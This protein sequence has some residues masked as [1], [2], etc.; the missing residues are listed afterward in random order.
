MLGIAAEKLGISVSIITTSRQVELLQL[1][2]RRLSSNLTFVVSDNQFE[3]DG[4]ALGHA[5][6]QKFSIPPSEIVELV[7][8]SALCISD[9]LVWPARFANRF[10]LL[11]NFLWSEYWDFREGPIEAVLIQRDLEYQSAALI[12]GRFANE[13]LAWSDDKQ[14]PVSSTYKFLRYDTDQKARKLQIGPQAWVSKGTT[15]LATL[16]AIFGSRDQQERNQSLAF[17][18]TWELWQGKALPSVVFGR[19]GVGTL[20]DCMA[21][22][23]PLYPIGYDIK[24]PELTANRRFAEDFFEIEK[25][26]FASNNSWEAYKTAVEEIG[27]RR[28]SYLE[29]WDKISDNPENILT[30]LIE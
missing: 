6:M 27:H 9:N 14:I 22:G 1:E 24:D 19:P 28:T 2:A 13:G 16:E 4:P 25:I 17:K 15:G 21:A 3:L 26:G 10:L 20:R 7:S 8:G 5:A 30:R 29:K 12:G 23:I 11:A 18:E